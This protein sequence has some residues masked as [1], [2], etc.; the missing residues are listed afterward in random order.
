MVPRRSE[1]MP[2]CV[3]LAEATIGHTVG[4]I[5]SIGRREVPVYVLVMPW[6]PKIPSIY[7]NSRY[8]KA[9]H[10]IP[11]ASDATNVCNNVLK[12]LKKQSFPTK[13]VLMPIT[14]KMCTYV[15]ECREKFSEGFE[16]C[17]ASNSVVLGMLDKKRA[18]VL[19]KDAGL[20]VPE[21]FSPTSIDEIESLAQRCRFPVI[22][23]ST[24]WR[25]GGKTNFKVERCD[26][27]ERLFEIASQLIRSGATILVQEYIPGGDHAIEVYMFY[28]TRDGRTIHGCTG[29]KLRQIPPR[30]GNMA[31]GEAVRLPHVAQM[32]D[33]LLKHIDY[34]GLGG[35][36]YKRHGQESYFIEMSVRPEGFHML[37]IKAG[38][39]LPWLAYSDMVWNNNNQRPSIQE[40]A[41]YINTRSHI[42]LWYQHRNEVPALREIFKVLCQR[43]IQFDLWNWRDPLPWFVATKG[44]LKELLT[45][46]KMK[47][48]NIAD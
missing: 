30:I 16:V 28:R 23:K 45:R 39:D 8:C 7:A 43:R 18:Y 25:K 40:K 9:V 14:D 41:C 24:W 46:M 29:R 11:K 47:L 33:V 4:M 37:A 20:K 35:I 6:D 1:E 31:S 5:R 27:R 19:A 32:S 22:I 17:M 26:C 38:V 3:I 12:W 10:T 44:W 15:A 2:A 36:E 42:S 13:P 34:R 48:F 21:T